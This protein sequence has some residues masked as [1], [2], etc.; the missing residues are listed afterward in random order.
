M[1]KDRI[2]IVGAGIAGLTAAINLA[3]NGSNVIV[4]E[5]NP[6]YPGGRLKGDWQH[7]ENWTNKRDTIDR[8]IELGLEINFPTKPAYKLSMFTP[9]FKRIDVKSSKP[10]FYSV[11]RGRPKESI[12]WGLFKQARKE[13]VEIVFGKPIR[14][15]NVDIVATGPQKIFAYVSG[16][17]FELDREDENFVLIDKHLSLIYSYFSVINKK[18]TLASAHWDFR[19]ANQ[20]IVE[21]RKKI[22]RLLGITVKDGE[23]FQAKAG[24]S[25]E[26]PLVKDKTLFVGEAAGIQDNFAGFGMMSAIRSGYLA[27]KTLMEVSDSKK[28]GLYYKKL[29]K[30]ELL[31]SMQAS[32]VNFALTMIIPNRL[33][34]YLVPTAVMVKSDFREVLTKAYCKSPFHSLL[35]PFLWQGRKVVEKISQRYY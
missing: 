27:A 17:N 19:R 20:Y 31:P 35:F 22:S 1:S 11:R 24:F 8:L 34:N 7:L 4:Y 14:D 13:G 33:L 10:L 2:K 21:F 3:R 5:I 26:G 30:K 28:Q 9:S 23:F 12:D 32:Y 6:R 16:I 25:L 15:E 29:C 18:A